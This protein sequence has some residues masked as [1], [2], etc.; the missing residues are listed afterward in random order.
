[1][2]YPK[3]IGVMLKKGYATAG[4]DKARAALQETHARPGD[5]AYVNRQGVPVADQLVVTYEVVREQ[6]GGGPLLRT[7]DDR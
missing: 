5:R 7:V 3:R 2:E 4:I 6:A 1:M